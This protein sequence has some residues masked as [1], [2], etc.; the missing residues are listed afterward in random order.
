MTNPLDFDALLKPISEAQPCGID[1]SFSSAFDDITFA[2]REDDATLAQGD[3]VTTLK[4]ADWSQVLKLTTTL[5]SDKTKDIRLAVWLTE[6]LGKMQSFAG[7]SQGFALIDQLCERYWDDLHPL[8]DGDDQEQRTGNFTW[9]VQRTAVLLK[10]LPVT[11]GNPG[12]S[13]N[14]MQSALALQQAMD[15][16]PD[17]AATLAEEK[18]TVAMFQ[19]AI[20]SSR[21]AFYET[22][23]QDLQTLHTTFAAFTVRVDTLLGAEA[24]SYRVAQTALEE[25]SA[26][27]ERSARQLGVGAAPSPTQKSAG[28]T[29]TGAEVHG[30]GPIATRAQALQQ[31][32]LVAD[33][34][35]RTEP[36]SPVA[37][38][39]DKAANWGDMPLHAWLRAVIKDGGALTQLEEVLGVERSR[40]ADSGE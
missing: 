3:W 5:T 17:Q 15:R 35:R 37:Y 32:R 33:Y 12:Y 23:T 1:L 14:D 19:Q 10:Q 21:Q 13:Y 18:I 28:T 39:A 2:R 9:L 26:L 20:S 25:V 29:A 8:P 40:N 31:L 36:H 38:L 27:V 30:S 34:F 22:L 6:A 7:L 24:P 16:D 4:Q 11:L